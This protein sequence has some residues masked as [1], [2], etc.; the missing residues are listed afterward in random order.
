MSDVLQRILDFAAAKEREA[1]AFFKEWGQ[2][3]DDLKVRALLAEVAAAENG[4]WQI[5]R[6]VV[7][8]DLLPSAAKA[9]AV[10]E[11]TRWLVEVPVA[12]GA[13]LREAIS[14]AIHRKVVAAALYEKLERLGGETGPLLQALKNDEL[15]HK[16][17]LEAMFPSEV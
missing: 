2:R 8:Q 11:V 4:H 14:A 17:L 15:R 16:D 9:P 10:S 7:P 6:H 5:L 3:V 13:T 12:A 1:E